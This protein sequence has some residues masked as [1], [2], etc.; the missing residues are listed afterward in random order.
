M[1]D[2]EVQ[3]ST[4]LAVRRLQAFVSH[5]SDQALVTISNML[6]TAPELI[7]KFEGLLN[8]CLFMYLDS[9]DLYRYK[10]VVKH[11]FSTVLPTT[12]MVV[13]VGIVFG[14]L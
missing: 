4:D 10:R 7:E 8:E 11:F 14:R 13:K 6:R 3:G 1:Q 9:F 5:N 2:S 12:R